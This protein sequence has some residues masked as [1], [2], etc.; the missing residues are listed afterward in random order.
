MAQC[1]L[2]L[3]LLSTAAFGADVYRTRAADGT[4]SYSDRPQGE[5]S[6]YVGVTTPR[7]GAAA[8]A[9]QRQARG[10]A[11]NSATAEAPAV[12]AVPTGPTA[13]QLREQRQKNCEIARERQ[14]RFTVSRRLFRTT[15][16]GEREY[17]SDP[18]IDEARAK[19]AADVEDWCG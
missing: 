13:A 6:E 19:A 8:N 11:A 12:P 17:L 14:Q 10:A 1:T 3:A 2:F 16:D 9:Q 4:I 7:A 5:N 15:A 18:Q